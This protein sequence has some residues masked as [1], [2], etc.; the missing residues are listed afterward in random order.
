MPGGLWLRGGLAQDSDMNSELHLPSAPRPQPAFR[1]S[2]GEPTQLHTPKKLGLGR[3][4]DSRRAFLPRGNLH[5]N[6]PVLETLPRVAKVFCSTKTLVGLPKLLLG[7]SVH[8]LAKSG[9]NEHPAQP[10]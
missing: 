1:T 4:G 3:V 6:T 8:L 10:V 9:L 2:V 7:P 5:R